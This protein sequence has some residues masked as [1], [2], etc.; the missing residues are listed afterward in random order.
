ML[1]GMMVLPLHEVALS[2]TKM[3]SVQSLKMVTLASDCLQS[4][5]YFA[6]SL[7]NQ[8]IMMVEYDRFMYVYKQRTGRDA[9][10]I[11]KSSV[12]MLDTIATWLT[13]PHDQTIQC[14]V[15]FFFSNIASEDEAQV[16]FT[17]SPDTHFSFVHSGSSC[18]STVRI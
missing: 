11:F 2:A 4:I 17:P 13:Y 10:T 1:L 14:N 18:S 15:L 9:P 16:R 5:T 6:N 7:E 3:L 8:K 12:H